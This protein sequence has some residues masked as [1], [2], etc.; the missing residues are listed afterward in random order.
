MKRHRTRGRQR[1][2]TLIELLLT[3]TILALAGAL[4]SGALGAGLRAWQ[5]GLNSGREE[6]VARIVLE[7]IATQLRAAVDS[8]AIKDG[9]HA[10]AFAAGEEDLR[11]VTLAAGQAPVQV[12]YGMQVDGGGRFLLYREFPWPDKAFFGE[13]RPRREERIVEITG[14]TLSV[15]ARTNESDTGESDTGEPDRG[16]ELSPPPWSP[17][18]RV[19]P[20]SVSVAITV[21]DSGASEPRQYQATVPIP[22]RGTR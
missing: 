1:G 8:P 3:L 18:D 20:A 13:S 6:L 12:S 11:F 2:L 19:L 21:G 15:V 7:R 16:G 5:Q 4:V 9:E 14:F 17:L 10:V 22:T